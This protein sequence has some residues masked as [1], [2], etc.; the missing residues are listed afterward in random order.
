[1]KTLKGRFG[2][3]KPA[4]PQPEAT[5]PAR[6]NVYAGERGRLNLR[7]LV[8][9]LEDIE[10]V[11]NLRNMTKNDLAGHMLAAGTAGALAELDGEA[12]QAERERIRAQRKG[13]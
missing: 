12:V 2:G 5:A 9:L 4:D 8:D 7:L 6:S 10:V 13:G 11:A 3:S 1:M